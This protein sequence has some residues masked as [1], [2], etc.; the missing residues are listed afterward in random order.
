LRT[1]CAI[2]ESEPDEAAGRQTR[3]RRRACFSHASND[4]VL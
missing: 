4:R 3:R 1:D 2:L